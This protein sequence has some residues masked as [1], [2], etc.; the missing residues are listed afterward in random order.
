MDKISSRTDVSNAWNF[1]FDDNESDG[2]DVAAFEYADSQKLDEDFPLSKQ[3]L[4]ENSRGLEDGLERS[5]RPPKVFEREYSDSSSR[6]PGVGFNDFDEE[7]DDDVDSYEIVT[8]NEVPKTSR[9]D[10]SELEADSESEDVESTESKWHARGNTK[11]PTRGRK[12]MHRK[13]FSDSEDAE[14]DFDT[15]DDLPI[16]PNWKSSHVAN[17][18][19]QNRSRGAMT[20]GSDDDSGFSSGT[21]DETVRPKNKGN[22]RGS[23]GMDHIRGGRSTFKA[24]FPE[25]DSDDD[26]RYQND[27]QRYKAGPARQGK[28]SGARSGMV[29]DMKSSRNSDFSRSSGPKSFNKGIPENSHSKRAKNARDSTLSKF[30]SHRQGGSFNKRG[31]RSNNF[32][33]QSDSYVDDDRPRRP[34]NNVR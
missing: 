5:S 9:I 22:R 33:N 2:A 1:D 17:P 7:D 8:Q 20:F 14:L 12:Q 32:D 16:H 18:K 6:R 31:G 34:R 29:A 4:R 26:L 3:T 24:S 23:N 27:R 11:F 25:K 15:D 13:T 10:L 30:R 21:D 28:S 19:Q